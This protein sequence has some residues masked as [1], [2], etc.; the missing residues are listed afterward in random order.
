MRWAKTKFDWNQ[1]RAFLVTAEEGSLSAAARA[2]ELTQ[3]TLSRQVAGLEETLGVTL[4]ERTPRAL[5]LTQTGIQLLEHFRIMGSAADRISI[6]ATGQSHSITG[7]V[8]ITSTDMMATHYILPIIK[9]IKPIAPEL[10]IEFITSNQLSNLM[11][12]EAD[13][14]IRHSRPQEDNLIAKRLRDT[15]A[16]LMASSSYLDETGRPSKVSDIDS[17]MYVGAE[18]PER[19][20]GV[21]AAQG[22]SFTSA[23]FNY[24]TSNGTVLLELVRQGFGISF[25]PVEMLERYPELEIVWPEFEPMQIESWLVTHRE[26]RTNAGIRLVFDQISEGL[27]YDQRSQ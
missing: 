16:H 20:L 13:I 27:G 1:A 11:Q 12:R 25:L 18:Y 8:A 3:P 14:A 10:Q 6:A 23:N 26:L 24:H 7:N 22:L 5:L 19:L 4:F 21:L 9:R 2:L 17:M 15:T